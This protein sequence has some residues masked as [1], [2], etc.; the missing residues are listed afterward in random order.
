VIVGSQIS[1]RNRE[2]IE[3]VLQENLSHVKLRCAQRD[4]RH[5]RVVV[6][7][8]PSVLRNRLLEQIAAFPQLGI[9][10]RIERLEVSTPRFYA[11]TKSLV[12]NGLIT[13]PVHRPQRK[14]RGG[15]GTS[16]AGVLDAQ[17]AEPVPDRTET[18]H[19]S[20]LVFACGPAPVD[21]LDDL[22]RKA[23]ARHLV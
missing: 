3:K 9:R 2:R 17:R 22:E 19:A 4:A 10:Q 1:A 20:L 11:A 21:G 16:S 12:E 7:D 8:D 5:F 18:I 14:S 13:A 23:H 15:R 6:Q